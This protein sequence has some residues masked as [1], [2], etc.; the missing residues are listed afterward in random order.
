M[1]LHVLH[2]GDGYEYL[3]SQVATADREREHGQELTDYYSAHGTPPGTWFGGGLEDLARMDADTEIADEHRISD[4]ATVSEPQMKALFGEGMHPNADP[5]V[6]ASIKS[7]MDPKKA[8]KEARLGRKF[9]DFAND[10]PLLK[11]HRA[12]L[13]Q[14]AVDNARRPSKA[15]SGALMEKVGTAL[16]EE[17]HKRSA[18]NPQEL[19]SWISA[20]KNRVRQPVAGQDLVFTPP[21]SVSTMWALADDDLRRQ[22]ERIHHET[23]KGTLGWIEKEACFTRTGAT[24]QEHQ[25]TTGMVATLYDH[26]DSRAGDPNLHTHAVVSIKVCTEKDGKWRALDGATL[27]RYAVAASQRYNA[28]I[29]SKMHTELGFGL[30]ERSTGRGRQNVVEIA[31]VPQQLCE[32]FSSRRTQIETRRDQLVAEYRQK[33]DRMPSAKAMYALYQQANLDTRAG[34]QEPQTLREM[35]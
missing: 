22:I 19:W 35:L 32:M 15:E 24:S 6:E 18:Q 34:K 12:A 26:Y 27:H 3:T 2:A 28:A 29:M 10:I 31:E 8:V 5:M 21:K 30:T 11:A 16:F 17:T 33:H 25:D 14:F 1:T 4:G 13:E 20:Q 9:P 23:V 7:G